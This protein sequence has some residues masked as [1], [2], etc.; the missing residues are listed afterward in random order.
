MRSRMRVRRCGRQ[1]KL[2][3]ADRP[4][5]MGALTGFRYWDMIKPLKALGIHHQPVGRNSED[6]NPPQIQKGQIFLPF[7]ALALK[8]SK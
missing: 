3:F 5:L 1:L 7:G 2:L 4:H 6:R 8:G